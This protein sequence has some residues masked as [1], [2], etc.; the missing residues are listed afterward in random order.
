MTTINHGGSGAMDHPERRISIG[1]RELTKSFGGNVAVNQV[2]LNIAEGSCTGIIGPNG[3]GKTTLLNLLSGELKPDSGQI[4]LDGA[5]ITRLPPHERT[6]LG[7][8]RSFQHANLF[9]NLTVLENVRLS[10]Q[11]RRSKEWNIFFSHQKDTHCY[12][13]AMETLER[14][15]LAS[16]KGTPAFSLTHGEK[17]KLELAMILS[18]DPKILLLDEPTAGMAMEE[19]PPI[20]AI[21][22]KIHENSS[23]TILLVEHRM[24]FVC[25]LVEKMAVLLLGRMIA[26]DRTEIVTRDPRVASAYL[27]EEI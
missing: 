27:G 10:V 9:P 4:F 17:R 8:G 3:S 5:E 6:L 11:A 1:I 15:D 21:L 25:S 2:S 12:I 23:G 26:Y 19:V 24:D 7:V 16:K 20:L 13:R 18:Q 14:V 22:K